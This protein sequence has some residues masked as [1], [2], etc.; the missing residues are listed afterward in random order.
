MSVSG[1]S[2]VDKGEGQHAR[3]PIHPAS[4]WVEAG[5]PRSY[6]IKED[7]LTKYRS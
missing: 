2:G 4:F 5:V 1:E 3:Y 7:V 6:S